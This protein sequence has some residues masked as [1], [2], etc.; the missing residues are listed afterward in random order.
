MENFHTKNEI[1]NAKEVRELLRIS[2]GTLNKL[3]IPKISIR[4]R[5][6]YKKSDI[7]K[8]ITENTNEVKNEP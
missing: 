1:L 4:R 5:V 7:I 8:F 2:K 3:P 6:L